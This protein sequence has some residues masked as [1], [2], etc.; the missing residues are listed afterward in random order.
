MYLY[1]HFM[2]FGG[3]E[4]TI[5]HGGSMVGFG[6]GSLIASYL[7]RKFD[8]KGGVYFG[9]FLSIGSNFLLAALFLTGVLV[10]GQSTTLFSLTNSLCIHLVRSVPWA[11]LDGQWHHLS[12][13]HL[14]DG[15]RHR[16]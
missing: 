4:K 7:T 5:A 9:G 13:R 2:R 10:P 15:R 11:V 8:K 3:V 14:Y 16:N 1:E 6:I 12:D